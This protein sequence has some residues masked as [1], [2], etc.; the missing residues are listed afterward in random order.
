MK[1]ASASP[2]SCANDKI[3]D[4]VELCRL[5]VD[6]DERGAVALGHQRESGRRPHHQRRADGEKQVAAARQFFGP[7]HR[8]P[9]HR[10]AERHRRRLDEAAAG[11]IRRVAAVALEPRAH[12]LDLVADAAVEAGGV[13]RVA[14]QLDDVRGGKARGLVQIVDVLRHHR[15]RLAGPVE[16]GERPMAAAR[17]GAAEAVL[18][19]ET[20]PPRLVAHVAARQEV[21][22]RDRPVPGPEAA[23]RAEIG[24]TALGRDA[25]AGER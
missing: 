1:G 24:D 10:L 8:L 3:G 4:V 13:G 23:R 18:H 5:A 7:A 17:P 16:A 12:R 19:G 9:R 2:M 20:P 14:V 25:G 21:V 11:A 6:D 15:R 22:E